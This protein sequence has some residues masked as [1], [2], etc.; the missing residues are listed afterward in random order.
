MLLC[1]T[2][3]RTMLGEDNYGALCCCCLRVW[4]R[5][6]QEQIRGPKSANKGSRFWTPYF[7][8]VAARY[9]VADAQ[10]PGLKTRLRTAGRYVLEKSDVFGR[11][12]SY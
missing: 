4:L 7:V 3:L 6:M 8:Y 10:S 11:L 2:L 12:I 1:D 9:S 5:D